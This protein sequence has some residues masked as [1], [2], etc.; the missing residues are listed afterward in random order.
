MRSIFLAFLVFAGCWVTKPVQA[1]AEEP[2]PA[3]YY[4]DF[5]DNCKAAYEALVSLR[6]QEGKRL[7][8]QERTTR[9]GNLIPVLLD[10]YDDCLTLLFVGDKRAFQKR[11]GNL[12]TRLALLEKGDKN[13]P[14]YR[15]AVGALYFQWAA[16][17]IRFNEYLTAGNDFRK[18][19]AQL[20]EN[21]K[22]FPDFKY[23]EVLMGME[24]AIIGTIPDN[25]KW[26]TNM[27]GMK[28]DVKRGTA[29]IAGFLNDHSKD[30]THFREEA[31]F[32]Y[33]YVNF[34]LLSDSKGTW[35]YL[36]ESGLDFKNNHLFAFMKANLALD[37]N[38]AA[39]AE[40]T[41]R[42]RNKSS[43]YMD[44]PL[45]HYQLGL[46]LLQKMDGDCLVHFEKFLSSNTGNLFVKDA[47]QKMSFYCLASGNLPKAMRYKN[48]IKLAG[49]TQI[50]ADKQAQRY[51]ESSSFPHP[52]LLKARLLC[53]GGYFNKALEQLHG[54][55]I[56]SFKQ[57]ADQLEFN[58]R[59]ARIYTLMGQPE[60][61]IPFYEKTIRAGAARQEHYAA[62][63]ALELGQIY[64]R[65]NE[66]EKAITSY[67]NCL[68]MKNHDYKASLDQKA[69]AG[70]NRLG[71]S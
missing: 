18:S 14:W 58:Y 32:Y 63:S 50:D 51:G 15:Y 70:I 54:Q 29:R 2:A 30:A 66:K 8:Q 1:A 69:K 39:V 47:Y 13:S 61:A 9:P 7:L 35:K 3:G 27:L 62:R 36:N 59:Y 52:I 44:V 23:N 60:K 20:K 6:I 45:F 53:D 11:K 65:Q 21:Q 25:Y 5:N 41:V 46:S 17:H 55:K 38:K 40:Q 31:A 22:R 48:Q 49:A 19:Y 26:V 43:A 16:I 42:N 67:R 10:N 24:E 4:F 71:G 28:G 56:S 34:F 57:V 37:D 33:C 12:S 64:E 68:S